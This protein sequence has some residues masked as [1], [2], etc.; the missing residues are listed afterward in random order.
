MKLEMLPPGQA[1]TRIIPRPIIGEIHPVR[2][3]ARRQ[4]KA[5]RR[6]I[7]HSIP[8]RTDL[9]FLNTSTKM[10]GLM[11]SATPYMTNARM[12]LMVFM[13]PAFRLT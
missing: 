6:T 13:P 12:M 9:G 7:W 3:T 4:V 2:R 5:G 1:A 8:K 10:C 11:P